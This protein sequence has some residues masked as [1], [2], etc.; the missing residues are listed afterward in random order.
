[1]ATNGVAPVSFSKTYPTFEMA[2]HTFQTVPV[3]PNDWAEAFQRGTA[4]EA[5]G[6]KK[7]KYLL[8]ISAE[9]TEELILLAISPEDREVW[10][11]LRDEKKI[12]WGQM[13]SLRMWIWEQMTERPFTP[14]SLSGALAGSSESSSADDVPSP[15]A[16][17]AA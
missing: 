17:P 15:E 3:D 16:T 12:D 9:G 8:G 7:G 10:K 4:A 5:E 13:N 1:M 2:G 6:A 11:R 14:D